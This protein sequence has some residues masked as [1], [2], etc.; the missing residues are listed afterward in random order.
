MYSFIQA[1]TPWGSTMSLFSSSLPMNSM[2]NVGE[3]YGTP[4]GTMFPRNLYR[5]L[6]VVV[7]SGEAHSGHFVTYRRGALRN[8]H[9]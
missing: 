7:H 8:A 6:A 1:G 3:S 5:L 4:F 9:R 2:G